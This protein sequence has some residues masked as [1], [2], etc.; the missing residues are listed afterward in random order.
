MVVS[1][2]FLNALNTPQA[3]NLPLAP[4]EYVAMYQEQLNN[5]LRLYFNQITNELAALTGNLGARYLQLPYGAFSDSTSQVAANTTTAY[6][7]TFDTTE[8]NGHGV[9]LSNSSQLTAEYT[10]IYNLQY[11]IQFANSD[12]ADADVDVWLRLNGTTEIPRTN[13]IY[14]VP[15]KHGAI[16]G[17]TIAAVNIFVA[18][19]AGDYVELVWHTD[20]VNTFI[21]AHTAA[22]SPTIPATPSVILTLTF[23]AA[24]FA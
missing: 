9:S 15:A 21:E 2:H 10:G 17:H 13:S 3:P 14:S 16:E 22:V 12:V 19:T 6:V 20:H 24:K 23:V 4:K 7:I 11:S 18:L 1:K 8:L 5:V